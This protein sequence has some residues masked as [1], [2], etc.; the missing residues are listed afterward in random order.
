MVERTHP[1]GRTTHPQ[2][3]GASD[4][5]AT[6]APGTPDLPLDYPEW[7]V[8]K[9]DTTYGAALGDRGRLVV[10]AGLRARQQWEQGTPLLFI[11]TPHGVVLTTRD[12]AKDLLRAQ[13][14][15]ASLVAELLAERRERAR[16][17]DAA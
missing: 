2:T 3:D 5:R 14:T 7:Y 4:E 12:Q 15:G 8:G 9:V 16:R 6:P 13:L 17:D 1:T 10:P 11:E